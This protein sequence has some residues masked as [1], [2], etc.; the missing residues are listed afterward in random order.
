MK[1]LDAFLIPR[2][3]EI[4]KRKNDGRERIDKKI[5]ENWFWVSIFFNYRI[6]AFTSRWRLTSLCMLRSTTSISEEST[7]R[8]L[9]NMPAS[10]MRSRPNWN[11]WCQ[12]SVL[13]VKFQLSIH[14]L[15]PSDS[16]FMISRI[17]IKFVFECFARFK[18]K[19]LS[20]A[21]AGK[22]A[23]LLV[24]KYEWVEKKLS[25]ASFSKR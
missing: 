13:I 24:D 15:K 16:I 22:Y 25:N 21:V 1:V 4:G 8:Q 10:N 17:K 5:P 14:E 11:R 12:N 20:F 7:L 19:R 18:F 3:F 6:S 2:S 23:I 9:V